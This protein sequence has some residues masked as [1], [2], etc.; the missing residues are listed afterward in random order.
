MTPEEHGHGQHSTEEEGE[1]N[2][3][4]RADDQP[5]EDPRASLL[6][7]F[8][9]TWGNDTPGPPQDRT[10]EQQEA[11]E[12]GYA[13]HPGFFGQE[14]PVQRCEEYYGGSPVRPGDPTEVPLEPDSPCGFSY[15]F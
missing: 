1:K 14:Q 2:R 12:R 4:K 11:E 8:S 15:G 5:P 9:A 6:V 3:K 7:W 10:A 13:C